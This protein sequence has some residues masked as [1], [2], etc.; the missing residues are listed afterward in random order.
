METIQV[1][2]RI[3]PFLPEEKEENSPI[4][5]LE[6]SDKKITITKGKKII[7]TQ[8][9]KI[10]IQKTK[11]E[12]IFD[13]L[14][15]I[16]TSAFN[17]INC[18][19]LAY[20][21]TGS[22][23]T[24]TM[25]GGDWTFNN[26]ENKNYRNILSDQFNFLVEPDFIVNP[27]SESNGIIPRIIVELFRNLEEK[28]EEIKIC[29]SYIQ[30]YNEKIYDLLIDNYS[31][32][33]L[34]NKK[35]FKITS[36]S[37]NEKIFEQ[38]PLKLRD[39]KRKG[40][41]IQGAKEIA[42]NTFYDVFQILKKGELNRK[43]RETIKNDMSSR[44]HTIFIVYYS[45]ISK[46]L[47][48][49]ISF[50][51]LA[52]SEK[53][54][55]NEFYE[56]AHLNELKSINKSLSVLGNVIHALSIKNL[57]VKKIHSTLD[58]NKKKNNKSASDIFKNKSKNKNLKINNSKGKM[59]LN[60]TNNNNSIRSNTK[61]LTN[62]S[63]KSSG[64]TLKNSTSNKNLPSLKINNLQNKNPRS[65]SSRKNTMNQKRTLTSKS[66]S[67][68]KI[69]DKDKDKEIKSTTQHI[70]VYKYHIPY[71]DSQLTYLLKD[72][73][74]GNSKTFLIA[75]ISPNEAN[76]DES[77][78]T[79]LFALRAKKIESKVIQNKLIDN[80]LSKSL[81]INGGRMNKLNN[82]VTELRQLLEIRTKRGTLKPIQEEFIKLK[83]ENIELR[84]YVENINNNNISRII[85][86]NQKLKKEIQLLK[87][88]KD[89]NEE[90]KNKKKV[91]PLYTDIN[92]AMKNNYDNFAV[93]KHLKSNRS[94][95][96]L[97][98]YEKNVFTKTG[99]NIIDFRP[100]SVIKKQEPYFSYINT[101]N[102]NNFS[103]PNF[104]NYYNNNNNNVNYNSSLLDNEYAEI[105]RK[106]LKKLDEMY[107]PQNPKNKENMKN[108]SQ[109]RYN[110]NSDDFSGI[111]D[112][113]GLNSY[114]Y[115]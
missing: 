18:T 33:N 39:D 113:F 62:K 69:K 16:I 72:S 65:L 105:T 53:Y 97:D 27:F 45:N 2:I 84:N 29:V 60:K 59:P 104:N 73:I 35:D 106:R 51:D 101:P 64:S 114:E 40:V 34:K 22:G 70:Q 6:N 4:E 86:E 31:Y 99:K 9:D 3:R 92:V 82:E 109:N 44:S 58:K 115:Y 43:K 108:L 26:Q 48:S 14:K 56:D 25:F 112:E 17:G 28:E 85:K 46:K 78:N 98:N 74:G 10:F 77:Y 93:P 88:N 38:P 12:E 8:F 21:Q 83:E 95:G 24:F 32:D 50:C 37:S 19:I 89:L 49:K 66:K 76:F 90:K 81:D 54:D 68:S 96:N 42:V 1:A 100:N 103:T 55:I 110:I 91:Y 75:N 107:N 80:N 79:I 7:Q 94:K 52:G 5:V 41:I 71:K 102:Q 30:V 15:P 111:N 47:T 61:K 57:E 87:S 63:L 13:F 11:Q 20:G 23:K 67:K 36:K